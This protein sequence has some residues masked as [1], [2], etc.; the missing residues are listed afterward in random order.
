VGY[1]EL[2]LGASEGKTGNVLD[3]R[4]GSEEESKR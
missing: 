2:P 4:H 3:E 1:Y